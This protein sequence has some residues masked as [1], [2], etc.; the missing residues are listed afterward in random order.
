MLPT[1]DS[2]WAA[3]ELARRFGCRSGSSRSRPRTRTASR[4]G[5]AARVTGRP[6]IL[7]FN[8]CYHGTVDETFATLRDGRLAGLREG[9]VGPRSTR[10]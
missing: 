9:N 5:S 8:Y 3:E 10:R 1:E 7:V 2:A 4:S 6:K